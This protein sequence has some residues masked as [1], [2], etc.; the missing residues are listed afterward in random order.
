[1]H[2]CGIYIGYAQRELKAAAWIKCWYFQK[3]RV[4]F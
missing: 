3:L 1:M 4:H 2:G